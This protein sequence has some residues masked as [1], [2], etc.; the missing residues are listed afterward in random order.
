MTSRRWPLENCSRVASSLTTRSSWPWLTVITETRGD[1]PIGDFT[2][3]PAR[4]TPPDIRPIFPFEPDLCALA[5]GGD[6]SPTGQGRG[7]TQAMQTLRSPEWS[8]HRKRETRDR[9]AEF[10]HAGTSPVADRALTRGSCRSFSDSRA[11]D[12]SVSL[13]GRWRTVRFSRDDCRVRIGVDTR[14]P[15]LSP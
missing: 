15:W 13:L 10:Y 6:T 11:L 1:P 8:S 9:S 4:V 5:G 3:A 12:C 7:S 2:L 14:L